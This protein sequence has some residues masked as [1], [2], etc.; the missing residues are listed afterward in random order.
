LS[1]EVFVSKYLIQLPSKEILEEF[2]R[3]EL[4]IK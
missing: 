2:I 1:H 4:K 3:G